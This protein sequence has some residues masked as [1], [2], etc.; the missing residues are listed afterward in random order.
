[1]RAIAAAGLLAVLL[2]GCAYHHYQRVYS[3]EPNLSAGQRAAASAVLERYFNEAGYILKQKYRDHS[4]RSQVS[5]FQIPRS[6]ELKVR[7]GRLFVAV[8]DNGVI[9]LSHDEWFLINTPFG[10]GAHLP[11]DLVGAARTELLARIRAEVNSP[12]DLRLS[13]RSHY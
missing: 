5:V 2:A 13:R 12:A 1:M 8:R 11:G 9:E 7:D 10:A 3:L 4:D 6:T